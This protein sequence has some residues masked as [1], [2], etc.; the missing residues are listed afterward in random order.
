MKRQEIIKQYVESL[1]EDNELDYIFPILLER[2]GYR[3]L[4]TPRQSKGQSQ[5]GRD[6]IAIKKIK[7]VSTLFLFELKGFGSKDITDRTLNEK[8]G[9]IESLRASKYTPYEDVSVPNLC[10]FPR[11]YVFVHNGL[12][13]ANALPTFNGFKSAK[14]KNRILKKQDVRF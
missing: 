11:Y 3:V 13:D 1:K 6:V 7:G 8:D 12:I 2:M 4:S 10:N 14:T 9:L 5:Y